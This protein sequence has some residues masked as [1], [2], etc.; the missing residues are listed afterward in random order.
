MALLAAAAQ[1]ARAESVLDEAKARGELVL[2]TELQYAPFEFTDN[3]KPVGYSVDLMDLV[4]ADLGVKLRYVDIPFASVLPGLD[5]KKFDM[6]EA[7]STITKARMERY[8][9]TL[10]IADAT[11]ALVKRKGDGSVMK[12]Q[13]IAG[14]IVGGTKGSA[15]TKLL[16]DYVQ[17][18]PGGVQEIK[19]YIGSPNAYADLEA[20]RIVAVAGSL[21]NLAYLV[22]TRSQSFELVLPPFG[23]KAYLAWLARKDDASKPLIDAIDIAL[24]KLTKSGKIKELQLKWFGVAVELPTDGV[25]A[26]L[27]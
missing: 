15:Q 9:F 10:P 6:V 7:T 12:P 8:Y 1:S 14:K 26:P 23:P 3:G 4:A 18:L 22:K 20:G 2:G 24:V 27:Y 13:D 21:P 17:T 11:V 16:Q 19:E 25:P 5:A